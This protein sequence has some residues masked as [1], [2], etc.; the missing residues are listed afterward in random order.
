V[1]RVELR[2]RKD[3]STFWARVDG[4]AVDPQ[5]PHKGSVWTVEDIT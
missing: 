2:R 5:D 4:R 1:R 3:G